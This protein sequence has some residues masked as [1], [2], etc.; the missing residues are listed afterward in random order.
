MTDKNP[1]TS[2]SRQVRR[3]HSQRQR[4]RALLI[5]SGAV[6]L[7]I[8]VIAAA[9]FY[10]R[11]QQPPAGG[12]DDFTA[13][14]PLGDPDA[15]V[16]VILF[17]DYANAAC[18]GWHNAGYW[19]QMQERFGEDQLVFIYRHFPDEQNEQSL[20]AAEAAQCA[21]DQDAFWAY[22]DAIMTET[23]IDGMTESRLKRIAA[24]LG[25]DRSTFNRCLTAG[26]Y[27]DYV[28]D[29]KRVGQENG[30]DVPPFAFVNGLPTDPN[31]IFLMT[32][33]QANLAVDAGDSA[34]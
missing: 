18:R 11:S 3:T 32:E 26:K 10:S 24:D 30:V 13:I 21:A 14:V 28:I 8:I 9:V 4:R 22:H 7:L 1:N 2:Q 12:W 6:L 15:A 16:N 29:D 34:E 5:G 27:A 33:I 20:L 25:L 31:P 23:E 17:C 19:Q